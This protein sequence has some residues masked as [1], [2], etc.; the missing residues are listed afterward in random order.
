[1]FVF[2]VSSR[3]TRD[4][5]HWRIEKFRS[6]EVLAAAMPRLDS[7]SRCVVVCCG[8]LRCV[9]VCCGVLRCVAVWCSV[10]QCGAVCCRESLTRISDS[11]HAEMCHVTH[12]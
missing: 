7:V 5:A 11:D 1:V 9:A 6:L 3:C 8:V 12:E 4:D 2:T 10:S